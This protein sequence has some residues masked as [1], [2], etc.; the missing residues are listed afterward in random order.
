MLLVVTNKTDLACDYLILY[1]NDHRIPFVRIN[2]EDLGRSFSLDLTVDAAGVDFHLS[3]HGRPALTAKQVGG[4]Y[5]RQPRPPRAPPDIALSDV[6]FAER[7][8][9]ET[10]RSLWR[11]IDAHKWVNHPRNLWLA[12]NKIEQLC[13]ARDLGMKVPE[14]IVTTE[15][16]SVRAFMERLDGK[17][18]CKAVKHGFMYSETTTELAPTQRIDSAYLEVFDTFAAVPMIYQREIPKAFDV[19]VTVVG[20]EVFATAIHSQAHRET[21]VDWRVWDLCDFDLEHER[22]TLPDEVVENCLRATAHYGL[23][24]SAIDL[25]RGTDG[26]FYFLELNPNGQWAWI[27]RKTGQPIRRALVQC[28]GYG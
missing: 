15:R 10:L 13:V 5:F 3:P 11:L 7:E 18:I 21:E 9:A 20:T 8:A 25:I 2:T 28:M 4:V 24:Y 14:T 12:S 23:R 19:R 27:E 16:S 6:E 26:E 22:I 1:L 17:L